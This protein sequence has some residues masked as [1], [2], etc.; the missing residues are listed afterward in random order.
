[1]P[2][3]QREAALAYGMNRRQVLTR[4]VGPQMLRHA[5]PALSNNWLVMIKS[6]SIV[7][8]IGLS[9]MMSRA[10]QAAPR[11]LP[12]L[13]RGRA[14]VPGLHHPVPLGFAWLGAP[15]GGC[16]PGGALTTQR[17]WISKPST[18]ACRCTSTGWG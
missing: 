18:T 16:A 1:V 12:V 4:V 9:D 17:P 6:T 3:G 5:L 10:G 8:V 15:S 11:A 7:S 13:R 14:H 2:P